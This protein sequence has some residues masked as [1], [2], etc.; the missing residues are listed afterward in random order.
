MDRQIRGAGTTPSDWESWL[1]TNVSPWTPPS[2]AIC[3]RLVVVTPHPDDEILMCGGLLQRH[4]AGGGTALV[5]GVTDGEASHREVASVQE[6]ALRATRR[7]ES[8][9]GLAVLGSSL[10]PVHRLA[11]PDGHVAA[12]AD[13]LNRHLLSTLM[14]GDLVVTTWHLDGHPD[15]EA[16]GSIA[17]EACERVGCR[18]LE[19]PVWM[20]HWGHPGL[21][22]IPLRTLGAFSLSPVEREKKLRALACHQSQLTPRDEDVPPVL[23]PAVLHRSG[24][25]AEYFFIEGR[26]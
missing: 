8:Q 21:R 15:H 11:I 25:P 4:L 20:W 5:V 17:R 13:T 12:H 24:W 18:L 2:S 3:P 1:A 7:T 22:A 9:G 14:P 16:T 23:N 6:E 10:D 19:A 26:A